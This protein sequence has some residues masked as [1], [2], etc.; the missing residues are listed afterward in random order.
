MA[1]GKRGFF[2]ELAL[3][4]CRGEKEKRGWLFGWVVINKKKK[5]KKAMEEGGGISLGGFGFGGECVFFAFNTIMQPNNNGGLPFSI[6]V[7]YM[8]TFWMNYQSSIITCH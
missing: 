8:M 5:K 1:F 3:D 4:F 2:H 6:L 7:N